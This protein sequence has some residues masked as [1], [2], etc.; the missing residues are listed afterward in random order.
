LHRLELPA[1][2]VSRISGPGL[3]AKARH[4]RE[5]TTVER[6]PAYQV[7]PGLAMSAE[8]LRMLSNA[9]FGQLT[10]ME[11]YCWVNDSIPAAP[12]R[13]ALALGR[14]LDEVRR[15]CTPAVLGFFEVADDDPERLVRPALVRQMTRLMDRREKQAQGG[16]DAARARREKKFQALS[17]S[18]SNHAATHV[19]LEK[20]RTEK[21]RTELGNGAD[22]K[23][24]PWVKEFEAAA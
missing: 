15:D 2:G 5:S 1:L 10:R 8:S 23:K 4:Y 7:Y 6:P 9:E 14:E 17:N 12:E 22:E 24:D 11:N 18:D 16:R 13:M 21:S 19:A 20:S 3:M